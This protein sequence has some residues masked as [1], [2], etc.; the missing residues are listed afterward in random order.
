M[1]RTAGVAKTL[2]PPG[3]VVTFEPKSVDA[4]DV[5]SVLLTSLQ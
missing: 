4:G 5:S 2:L 1:C 3:W